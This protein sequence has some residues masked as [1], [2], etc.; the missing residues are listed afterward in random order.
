MQID[1]EYGQFLIVTFHSCNRF[2]SST[3]QTDKEIQETVKVEASENRV[4]T[5]FFVF[6]RHFSWRHRE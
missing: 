5:S 4:S 2:S 6:I 1:L 3:F